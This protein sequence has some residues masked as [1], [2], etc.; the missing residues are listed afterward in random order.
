MPRE[1]SPE[2]MSNAVSFLSQAGETYATVAVRLDVPYWLVSGS[3][4]KVS[5]VMSVAERDELE[6]AAAE[7]DLTGGELLMDVFN[8]YIGAYRTKRRKQRAKQNPT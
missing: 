5:V 2:D 6:E 3:F 7:Q 4:R 1:L 8:E